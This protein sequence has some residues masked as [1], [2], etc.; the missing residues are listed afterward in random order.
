MSIRFCEN[1]PGE[2]N[3]FVLR[4]H[5]VKLPWRMVGAFCREDKM[6]V[7]PQSVEGSWSSKVRSGI[8]WNKFGHSQHVEVIGMDERSHWENIEWEVRRQGCSFRFGWKKKH[9]TYETEKEAWIV[10]TANENLL[11][12]CSV[13]C[14]VKHVC[15]FL[16]YLFEIGASIIFHF[17]IEKTAVK[18][19]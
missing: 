2:S 7:K 13:P 15:E 17:I 4:C 6:R 16:Q 19:D 11:S 14:T 18:R 5:S 10:I 9:Q 1:S 12:I 8:E 3:Q